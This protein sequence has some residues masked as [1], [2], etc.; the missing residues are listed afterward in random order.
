M[1]KK[2]KKLSAAEKAWKTMRKRYTKEEISERQSAAA[3]K[4]WETR[5]KNAK[6]NA[7]KR[8]KKKAR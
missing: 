6:K 5:R 4:A 7:K 2:K 1:A 8:A 3:H